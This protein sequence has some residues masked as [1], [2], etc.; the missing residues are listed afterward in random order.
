MTCEIMRFPQDSSL[1]SFDW[2]VSVATVQQ[3]G[4]FSLFPGID[5]SLAILEGKGIALDIGGALQQLT[6]RDPV[7]RFDGAADVHST[8]VDG[9]IVDFNV[10]TRRTAYTH[11]LERLAVTGQTALPC[12]A[13]TLLYVIN[14]S[15]SLSGADKLRAGDAVLFDEADSP[16]VLHSNAAKVMLVRLRRQ[17][18]EPTIA[19]ATASATRMPSIDADM[20]P[21]A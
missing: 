19:N 18:Q 3:G 21:P 7:L 14:G 11:T 16:R 9:D 17:D 12:D 5:R 4:A 8:L 20:M 15:C 10:M 13:L 6:P 2:R 1:E